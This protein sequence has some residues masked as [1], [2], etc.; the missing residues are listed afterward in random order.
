VTLLLVT[1]NTMATAIRERVRELAV[2]KAVGFSDQFV[3]WLVLAEGLTV[4]AIG[5]L[6][7]L[8]FAV[9]LIPGISRALAGL[10]PPLVLQPRDTALG[11]VFAVGAG[12]FSTILP[13]TSAMRLRVVDALRRV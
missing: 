8:V 2:L 12:I 1:G 4:A 5:G 7:G 11:L 13:A 3:L 10:L 6:L 9:V